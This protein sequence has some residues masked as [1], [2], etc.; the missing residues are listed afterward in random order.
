MQAIASERP[1]F[2]VQEFE[3]FIEEHGTGYFLRDPS[4]QFDCHYFDDVVFFE[5]YMFESKS[6]KDQLF[7][8][9]RE[10]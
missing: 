9:V 2:D 10:I 3:A 4:S 6:D 1:G 8:H 5:F 7:R